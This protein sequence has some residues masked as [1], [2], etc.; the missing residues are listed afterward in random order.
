MCQLYPLCLDIVAEDFNNTTYS[1]L[2]LCSGQTNLN[3]GNFLSL[4]SSDEPALK[5]SST[6][7][8]SMMG[9]LLGLQIKGKG[10][11]QVDN[12]PWCHADYII[13]DVEG[14]GLHKMWSLVERAEDHLVAEN[15]TQYLGSLSAIPVGVGKGRESNIDR[16][17]NKFV[18]KCM[19]ILRSSEGGLRKKGRIIGLSIASSIIHIVPRLGTGVAFRIVI[20]VGIWFRLV[21][22]RGIQLFLLKGDTPSPPYLRQRMKRGVSRRRPHE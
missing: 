20:V 22:I 9:I 18:D 15:A 1:L 13:S 4:S 6:C 10:I 7:V 21:Q 3:C 5:Q 16:K 12:V 17:V 11:A 8:N 19:K 2:A 14:K